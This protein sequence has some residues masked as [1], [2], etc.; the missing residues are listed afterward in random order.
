MGQRLKLND[1]FRRK[2]I[3]IFLIF[4]CVVCAIE[5]S[6]GIIFANT[7]QLD[8]SSI[9]NYMFIRTLLP[10]VLNFGMLFLV[11]YVNENEHIED[12]TKQLAIIL[13]ISGFCYVV[14]IFHSY[15]T[16][17][18]TALALPMAVAMLIGNK[19]M[20]KLSFALS[21]IGVLIH[22]YIQTY[23]YLFWNERLDYVIEN[24]FVSMIGFI[25]LYFIGNA[26]MDI[27][28]KAVLFMVEEMNNVK[29]ENW[30]V[31]HDETTGLY[32]S[33]VFNIKVKENCKLLKEN[34]INKL[35]ISYLDFDSIKELTDNYGQDAAETITTLFGKIL[36][37]KMN[38][39]VLIAKDDNDKFVILTTNKEIQGVLDII[40]EIKDEIFSNENI[41]I[42]EGKLTFA[43]GIVEYDGVST[44]EEFLSNCDKSLR[45]AKEN[46]KN[47]T[48]VVR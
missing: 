6:V 37:T 45:Q 44:A 41:M 23:D 19:K 46:G 42:S 48:V 25:A 32:N 21:T 10:T 20:Y 31:V 35:N 5:V 26:F 30:N 12:E 43:T 29:K 36:C 34:K 13:A 14:I 15:Y 24:F 22:M 4:A 2:I 39:N 17:I 7:G 9:W 3:K 28:E 1:D 8:G 16:G 33:L 38:E 27:F 18:I 11:Y 47:Q 40:N